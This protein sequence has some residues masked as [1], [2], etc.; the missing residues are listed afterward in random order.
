MAAVSDQEAKDGV[1]EKKK[2]V[3]KRHHFLVSGT[4][5]VCDT[6][7]APIKQVGTGAYGVVWYV[8]EK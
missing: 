2:I 8:Q 3:Q 1:I 7:Y 5:F 4:K 6:F